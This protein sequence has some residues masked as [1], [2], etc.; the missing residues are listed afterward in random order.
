MTGMWTSI[1]TQSKAPCSSAAS[2]RRPF[3]AT[4]TVCP[5][6]CNTRIAATRHRIVLDEQEAHGAAQCDDWSGNTD[7][8]PV[9]LQM[10]RPPNHVDGIVS[11]HGLRHVGRRTKPAAMGR[12]T[13]LRAGCQHGDRDSAEPRIRPHALDEHEAVH[14]GHLDVHERERERLIRSSVR[15]GAWHVEPSHRPPSRRSA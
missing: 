5:A 15:R 10:E 12:I 8:C 6:F 4:S 3:A 9:F 11:N 7:P 14:L 1:S 13:Y 2:A